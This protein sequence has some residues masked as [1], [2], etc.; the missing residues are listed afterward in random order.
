LTMSMF[1]Q[2][3]G[4]ELNFEYAIGNFP[5][6]FVRAAGN[7]NANLDVRTHIQTAA[8]VPNVIIVGAIDILGRRMEL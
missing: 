2:Q 7:N 8:S 4:N 1:G 5:G 3:L 6:L